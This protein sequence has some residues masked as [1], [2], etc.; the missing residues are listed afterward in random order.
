M[1]DADAAP[2]DTSTLSISGAQA[3]VLFDVD[4]THNAAGYFNLSLIGVLDVETQDNCHTLTITATNANGAVA[5][6]CVDGGSGTCG[7]STL[8]DTA[9]V[10]ICVEVS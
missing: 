7:G 4:T 3:G 6:G 5:A 9:T 1:T 2:H 10:N 8:T